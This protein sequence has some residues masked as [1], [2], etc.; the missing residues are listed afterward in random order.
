MNMAQGTDQ[1]LALLK[2]AVN[3][4]VLQNARNLFTFRGTDTLF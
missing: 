1:W 2:N 4:R 3:F